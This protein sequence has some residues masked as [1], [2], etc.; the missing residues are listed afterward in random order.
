[1]SGVRALL[2]PLVSRAQPLDGITLRVRVKVG[3]G[4]SVRL[5]VRISV[6]VSIRV[7]LRVRVNRGLL[8]QPRVPF[9]H[10]CDELLQVDLSNRDGELVPASRSGSGIGFGMIG[11]CDNLHSRYEGELGHLQFAFVDATDICKGQC[12]CHRKCQ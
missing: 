12:K 6:S 10:C 5:S 4:V 2:G 9:L 7:G 1:M 8:G 11:L 3:V